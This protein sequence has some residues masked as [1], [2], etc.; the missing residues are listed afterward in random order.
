M[1]HQPHTPRRHRQSNSRCSIG[2]L[3][4]DLPAFVPHKG[5]CPPSVMEC[6]N[7]THPAPT[8]ENGGRRLKCTEPD[9][10]YVKHALMHEE[11]FLMWE[12]ALK[13]MAKSAEVWPK[14]SKQHFNLYKWSTVMTKTVRSLLKCPTGRG[15]LSPT[16]V[17]QWEG[18]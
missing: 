14:N 8:L 18:R 16:F 12:L 2:S 11:C 10:P 9:C 7:K 6:H 3:E 15:S 1:K 13:R 5:C 17:S 4:G